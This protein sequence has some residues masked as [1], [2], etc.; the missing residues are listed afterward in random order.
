MRFL[1][2]SPPPRCQLPQPISAEKKSRGASPPPSVPQHNCCFAQHKAPARGSRNAQ[3]SSAT[4]LAALCGTTA[5]T[6][7]LFGRWAVLPGLGTSQTTHGRY[8]SE[9]AR[10]MPAPVC[11]PTLPVGSVASKCGTPRAIK[12]TSWVH[13]QY[14]PQPRFQT[15][16]CDW[17]DDRY[18]PPP[19]HNCGG[20]GLPQRQEWWDGGR[21]V[22]GRPSP[23]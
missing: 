2:A 6:G 10:A 12:R 21:R 18:E 23:S 22:A 1:Q 9:H 19:L 11:T 20:R 5:A 8:D 3:D 15:R 14:G 13:I 4:S 16:H 17:R 7:P